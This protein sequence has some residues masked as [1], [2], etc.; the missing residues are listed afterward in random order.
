MGLLM[1]LPKLPMLALLRAGDLL[2]ALDSRFEPRFGS[3][4]HLAS[5]FPFAGCGICLEPAGG[6][7]TTGPAGGFFSGT[8]LVV[9][10]FGGTGP[11]AGCLTLH[12]SLHGQR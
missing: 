3:D 7:L 10:L 8:S 11:V 6:V 5:G 4:S 2:R 9:K 1:P 12:C